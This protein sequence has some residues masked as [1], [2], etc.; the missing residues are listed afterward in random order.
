[1]DF[2]YLT[3]T[4]QRDQVKNRLLVLESEYLAN[5]TRVAELEANVAAGDDTEETVAAIE[6]HK[7]NL[8]I[9]DAA[10]EAATE[11]LDALPAPAPE[12]GKAK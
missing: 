2:K 8:G 9:I 10:Y 1:M 4:Q 6:Q 5:Q 7:A 12:K 3:A 11:Q